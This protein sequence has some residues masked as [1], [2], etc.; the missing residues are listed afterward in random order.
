MGWSFGLREGF[1]NQE[2]GDE[3]EREQALLKQQSREG[4]ELGHTVF[5]SCR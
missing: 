4:S 3:T 1:G 5:M 2:G